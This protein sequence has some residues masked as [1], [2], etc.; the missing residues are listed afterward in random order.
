[1]RILQRTKDI[2]IYHIKQSNKPILLVKFASRKHF[3][4]KKPIFWH[5]L[6]IIIYSPRHKLFVSRVRFL[7]TRCS[8]GCSTN[9]FVINSLSHSSLVKISS[10]HLHSQTLRARDLTF[11]S[12]HPVCQVSHVSWLI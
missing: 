6:V 12:P 2:I 8:R 10:R 4:K 9:T 11:C 3:G 7:Q 1:M 5:H